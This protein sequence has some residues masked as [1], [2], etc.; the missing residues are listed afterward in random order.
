M[1]TARSPKLKQGLIDLVKHIKKTHNTKE[2]TIVEIGSFVG[3]S[4]L[5]FAK[6]FKKV[7]SIDPYEQ[8]LFNHKLQKHKAEDI[9]KIFEDKIKNISNVVKIKNESL[10]F[11]KNFFHMVDIVY[12]DGLHDYEN[13]K[14]DILAWKPKCKLFIS[15]HDYWKTKFDGVIKAVNETVGLPD[16]TFQ[17]F[18]WIKR[19]K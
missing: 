6:Y 5:I 18:S 19:I 14:A 17:D 2:M 7:I 15:G 12:I 1:I 3:D 11:A 8:K 16:K 10:V 9:E 13:V 4:T